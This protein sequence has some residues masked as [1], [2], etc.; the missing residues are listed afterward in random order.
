M[1]IHKFDQSNS[2]L[3]LF[4]KVFLFIIVLIEGADVTFVGFN[5]NQRLVT[6]KTNVVDVIDITVE[7]SLARTLILRFHNLKFHVIEVKLLHISG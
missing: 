3:T 1:E 4:D 5:H 6:S 7:S 2:R